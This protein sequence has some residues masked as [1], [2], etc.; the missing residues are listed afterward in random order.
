MNLFNFGRKPNDSSAPSRQTE[1]GTGSGPARFSSVGSSAQRV[2]PAVASS[3]TDSAETA[4]IER[5]ADVGEFQRLLSEGADA[6]YAVPTA[7]GERLVALDLGAKR[8]VIL[9]A[10][11]LD[12]ARDAEVFQHLRSLKSQLRASGYLVLDERSALVT[13]ISD[14]RRNPGQRTHN[15]G[16]GLPLNLFLSWINTAESSD[17]SDVHVE[18]RGQNARV[19]VRVDGLLEPLADGNQGRYSR[20]DAEDAIAAGYNSTRKGNS[21]SQ[22]EAE[23]FVDCMIGFNTSRASGQLRFQNIPGRLGPKAVI[24]ILRT[25]IEVSA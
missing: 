25:E 13:V 20:K 19:R 14:I 1:G 11:G 17:A 24:R 12:S 4:V 16:K 3:A 23:E 5:F 15:G 7:I 22:Y 9:K 8:A 18:I 10:A 21:G 2:N 6:V